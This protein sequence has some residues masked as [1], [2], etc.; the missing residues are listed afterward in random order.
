MKK[1]KRILSF[2]MT[3]ALIFSMLPTF[4]CNASANSLSEAST[5]V[6][7]FSDEFYK[8]VYLDKP[9]SINRK[10]TQ[11]FNL[12]AD[13][14]A[15]IE[16]T[17]TDYAYKDYEIRENTEGRRALYNKLLSVGKGFYASSDAVQTEVNSETI[18]VIDQISISDTAYNLTYEQAIET[19]FT[20]RNDYPIF[21]FMASTL[22]AAEDDN[23]NLI[24]YITTTEDYDTA[25][26]RQACNSIINNGIAEYTA[27]VEDDFGPAEIAT[28]LYDKLTYDIPYAY[29]EDGTTPEDAPWAHNILGVLDKK[30]GVCE[31][32]ARTYELLLNYLEV[33]N[34]FVTGTSHGEKHAWNLV[35]I[36][37]KY[38]W[39]DC[40]W[41]A[42]KRSR[43]YNLK[44]NNYWNDHTPDTMDVATGS[45]LYELPDNISDDDCT[46]RQIRVYEDD[47]SIGFVKT[48]DDAFTL[49]TN[50]ASD[51]K[52][53]LSNRGEYY[54]YTAVWPTVNT[55]Q[56]E[57]TKCII[58]SGVFVCPNIELVTDATVNSDLILSCINFVTETNH[59]LDNNAICAQMNIQD[60]TIT[61]IE[62]VNFG[63]KLIDSYNPEGTMTSYDRL[64]VSIIGGDKSKLV[65]TEAGS[66]FMLDANKIAINTIEG[67]FIRCYVEEFNVPNVILS[68]SISFRGDSKAKINNLT[69]SGITFSSYV[70][71][72]LEVDNLSH[73]D[74]YDY[75]VIY[76]WDSSESQYPD[77][78]INSTDA[79]LYMNINGEW[80]DFDGYASPIATIVGA[81]IDNLCIKYNDV[82]KTAGFLVNEA[83]ELRRCTHSK[84]AV[85]VAAREASCTKEGY[86][87]HYK[88]PDC[89]TR[90]S[91]AYKTSI[92]PL[93]SVTIEKL[94]HSFEYVDG[95][96]PNC[97]E[98]GYNS[99][100]KCTVC[101][102]YFS[103]ESDEYEIKDYEAWKQ[104]AGAIEKTGIHTLSFV[105][106][107]DSSCTEA[108]YLSAYKCDYCSKYFED[109]NSITPIEDYEKWKTEGNGYLAK[110]SH[111]TVVNSSMPTCTIDGFKPYYFCDIC[112]TNYE[113]SECTKPIDDLSSWFEGAGK[114][115]MS[116]NLENGVCTYCGQSFVLETP[117]INILGVNGKAKLT[118]EGINNAGKY[119]I[120]RS[121]SENGTF[122]KVATVEGLS[123]TDTNAANGV[124][125]YYKAKAIS[126]TKDYTSSDFSSVLS[127]TTNPSAT[128]IKSVVNNASGIT[129]SW[130]KNSNAAGY[131]IQRKT[132]NGGWTTIKKLSNSST[133]SYV[134]KKASAN[135]SKYQYRIYCYINDGGQEYTG[136][137][138]KAKTIYR[139]SRPAIKKL[140]AAKKAF[141]VY[142]STNSKSSGYQLQYSTKSNFTSG[143]KTVT[144]KRPSTASKKLTKLSSKKKYYVRIRSYK[145]VG[146][147]KYY[148]AWSSVKNVKTR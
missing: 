90:Y 56:I 97:T 9:L 52:L 100:Y 34:V 104:G 119:E 115:P 133:T 116:H 138:S 67:S 96:M 139:L 110:Q 81:S 66:N 11:T 58:K 64:G 143:T 62:T 127:F 35:G 92:V 135:G 125:Y 3:L 136:E 68:N 113:D 32:Y 88:C 69:T 137:A 99:A 114:I 18:Y 72:N 95:K 59:F 87:E 84:D 89:N 19:Y 75:I 57:S 5:P 117:R 145:T 83:G 76:I 79:Y 42:G 130:A 61:I 144:I 38:Y 10:Y 129:I 13:D 108:G 27:V 23:G 78:T 65:N 21:Y 40:T 33:D 73:C 134:D 106:G 82:D 93:S 22:L 14:E 101:N 49:M 140:K 2:I 74:A 30:T 36:D 122:T 60:Y 98:A 15:L 7:E 50:E 48:I 16:K 17:S 126:A 80:T 45:I 148:S 8:V 103:I 131:V 47:K 120:Y 41:G 124:T 29:K 39:A 105:S 123:Y 109:E 86:I 107:K 94:Q 28:A 63:G 85:L 54:V 112:Q 1:R 53:V 44:G 51:Y 121:T 37:G 70:N 43:F 26:E 12:S 118:W 46:F 91:D 25:A 6:T 77:I 142:Y 147:V 20:F 102:K 55:I 132:N 128:A 71:S 31:S 141:T 146:G 4:A 111:N 24:I